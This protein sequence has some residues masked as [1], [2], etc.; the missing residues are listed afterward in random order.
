MRRMALVALITLNWGSGLTV[1]ASVCAIVLSAQAQQPIRVGTNFVRVDAYPTKDGRIVEGLVAADFEVLEDGVPQ[2]IDSF[3]HI[4]PVRGPQTARTQPSSQRDMLQA[5]ANPRNRIFLVFLDG[6]FVDD[7]HARSINEPLIKFLSTEL[8]DDDLVAIMT[9]N[10]SASQVTFGK[11]TEVLAETVRTAWWSWGRQNK[12]LDPELDKRQIQYELCYPSTDVPAK[13]IARS[14]ERATLEALQDAVNYL[15]S[16]REERKAI[17]TVTEGWL[18]YREDPD[19]DKAARE[20]GPARGRQDA[21]RPNR[22][23]HARGHQD[24]GQR[25]Q[26]P[27]SATASASIWRTSTT[28][29]FCARSSTTRIVA[30]APST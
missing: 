28:T 25:P 15:A 23:A 3:E 18:L 8:A 29:S 9:P 22:Q 26:S 2:K 7:V 6:P 24:F 27:K 1:A 19:L 17:I 14:R 30:T 5:V 12:Q 20:G 4:L 21:C 11:K 10:M 16:V 13:M